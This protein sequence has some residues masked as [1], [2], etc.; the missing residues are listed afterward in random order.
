MNKGHEANPYL[1]YIIEHYDRLPS[2]IALLH[3]H[4]DGYPRA[5]HTDAQDY[6]NVNALQSLNVDFV[7]RN[8]YANL[9]CIHIPGCPEEIQP[10]RDPYDAGRTTEHVFPAVW[11]TLF[12]NTEVP[13]VVGAPCCAQFA[14]SREQVRKR[15]REFYGRALQFLRDTALEDDAS[16]RVFEYL[17]H[18]IFG[19]E[20]V[21]CPPLEQCYRDV[22]GR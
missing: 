5:W 19:Q 13:A 1:T 16:G 8:G 6:S 3:S 18:I 21:Y 11:E 22:Y 10:F 9:R 20:A 17:W 15:P 2:T 12:N 4:E 14:V 7:Q